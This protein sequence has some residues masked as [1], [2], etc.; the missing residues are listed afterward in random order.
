MR[1]SLLSGFLIILIVANASAQDT[2]AINPLVQYQTIK[3]W[4]GEGGQN[5]QYEGIPPYLI[6]QIIN[7][8]VNS[9]GLTGLRY[10]SFQGNETFS[11]GAHHTWEWTNDN[12][13]PDTL[14]P[15][16]LDT[17]DI[18]YYM[19]NLFVPWKNAVVANGDPFNLYFSPS[20][21][22]GGSTGDIPAFLR[23]SPGEYAEYYTSNLLYLKNKYGLV[24]DYATMCNEAGNGNQFTAQVVGTMIKTVAPRMLAAGLTTTIQFPECVSAQTSW[25]YIQAE[26][27]DTAIWPYIKCLSY[28]LYGTNDPYRHLIDSFALTKGLITAQ[29]EYIGLGVQLLYQDLTLGGVSYWDYY[30]NSDYMPLNTNNT[31]FTF[32]AKY[33][34]DGQV[35]RHVRPGAVRVSAIANDTTLQPLA[36]THNGQ[37]T[38]VILNMNTSSTTHPITI[39]GLVPGDYA[40]GQSTGSGTPSELG[41]VTVG[42]SGTLTMTITAQT[43]ISIYPHSANLPPFASKWAATPTFLDLPASSVTLSASAFDPELSTVTY[44][45]AVDS[46]PRALM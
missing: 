23:Y 45:W 42:A 13:S 36:F 32:G 14:V 26:A 44:H 15:L 17:G 5:T 21:Y 4:G 6:T 24:A 1:T 22:Y 46:F 25:Q 38:A 43:V 31:W 11:Y 8:S 10:E 27:A 16:A 39:T 28:H 2:V 35:I 3:G 37:T 7:E 19:Q 9:L 34:T 40:V 29:R 41:V 12:G 33:W 30:G 18:D 20:W